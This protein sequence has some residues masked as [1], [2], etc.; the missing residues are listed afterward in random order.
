MAGVARIYDL[1]MTHQLDA[2]D[3]FIHCIQEQCARVRLNFF[4]IEPLWVEA[5]FQAL[6][7][8]DVW[9]RVV[10]NLHS[11]HHQPQ[12]IYHRLIRLASARNCRVIDPPD[13]ALAAFDK[14][15]LHARLM[16]GGVHVPHTVCVRGGEVARFRLSDGD[17]AALGSPFVIKPALGYGRRGVVLDA[18][19]ERDLARSQADWPEGDYLIQRLI[20]PRQINGDPA[21]FRVFYVFGAVWC[22]WWN[23]HTHRYRLVTPEEAATFGLKPLD[24]IVRQIAALTGMNFFSSEFA[25][26]DSGEFVA[27]DYVNDQCHTLS[28][29]AHPGIG[30]PD[31][32]LTAMAR[33]LIGAVREMLR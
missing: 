1:A 16:A 22:C 7:R 4:L 5:F 33:Q 14:A 8:G 12:D 24:E 28:Q 19:S 26:V 32:V 6:Q 27:I 11:E 18:T 20:R 29:S 31:A 3:L 9:P 30:V 25:Q 15:R 2:D 10:V 21:Y 17:R 23:C 13:T